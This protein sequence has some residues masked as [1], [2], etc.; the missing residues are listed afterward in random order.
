MPVLLY[1]SE[2]WKATKYDIKKCESFHTRCLRG[3]LRIFWPNNISNEKLRERT[4]SR[5][6]ENELKTRRWRYIGHILRKDNNN[7][8]KIA[9]TWAPEG[10]RKRGRPKE[11][12]RRTTER[13]RSE[14]RW[15]S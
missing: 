8:T 15:S 12:W 2:C 6:I 9:L 4:K 13:E 7:N 10:K 5:T 1:G 3:I 14:M 11:T